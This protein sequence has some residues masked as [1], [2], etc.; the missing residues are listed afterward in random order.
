MRVTSISPEGIRFL[1]LSA[2]G[3]L[4]VSSSVTIFSAIVLPIPGS[5]SAFPALAISPTDTPTSRIDLAAL[6]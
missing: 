5:S 1:S 3:M 4:P 2:E 6:R